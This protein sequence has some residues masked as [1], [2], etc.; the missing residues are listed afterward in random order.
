MNPSLANTRRRK[1][2]LNNVVNYV[3]SSLGRRMDL[4]FSFRS[5]L[6]SLTEEKGKLEIKKFQF[7]IGS[8]EALIIRR[9]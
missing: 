9:T 6:I 5:V 8:A 4:T 2:L 3:W 7:S 1:L